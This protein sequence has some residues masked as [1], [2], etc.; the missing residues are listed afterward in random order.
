[1]NA[2][3]TV[4]A[5]ATT[6]GNKPRPTVPLKGDQRDFVE[7]NHPL[8]FV[9]ADKFSDDCGLTRN[10]RV[11]AAYLGIIHA[12][13]G[14]DPTQKFQFSTYA[15]RCAVNFIQR[16]I[17][18]NSIIRIPFYL[19]NSS[20]AG[21]GEEHRFQAY[22]RTA[23]SV[24]SIFAADPEDNIDPEDR[25]GQAP[26]ISEQEELK[27]EELIG[28]LEELIGRLPERQKYVIKSRLAGLSL[29]AISNSLG[30]SKERVRQIEEKTIIR[31]KQQMDAFIGH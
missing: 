31:L 25:R 30:I 22:V 21:S 17:A 15:V 23:R 13:K 7:K 27:Q 3:A 10:E 28:A 16:E 20:T 12:A 19:C 6:G 26:R 5:P 8:A 18:K 24:R 11:S 9:A 14:F 4:P 1:M 29:K 2:T